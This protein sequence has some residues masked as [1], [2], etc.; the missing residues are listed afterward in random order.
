[1][2][3]LVL[4][5]DRHLQLVARRRQVQRRLTST[6][7]RVTASASWRSKPGGWICACFAQPLRLEQRREAEPESDDHDAATGGCCEEASHQKR[8]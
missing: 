3:V 7:G 5:A 1:M 2:S 6:S 4:P 8:K